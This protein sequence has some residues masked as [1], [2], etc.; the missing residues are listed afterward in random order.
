MATG[1]FGKLPASGD[2]VTRGL[3]DGVRPLL[4]RWLT[5]TLA[6]LAQRPEDWPPE[7][8]RGLIAHGGNALALLILPS[9]DTS[10][11]AFPL[12]AAALATGAGQAQVDDWADR[13]CP[14]LRLAREGELDAAGLIARI[15]ALGPDT[16]GPSL[17][18]PLLWCPGQPPQEP[19]ELLRQMVS[20]G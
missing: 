4:D 5:R 14:A 19:E 18:P 9:R 16:G 12:A 7:G 8:L 1:F 2:F 13:A 10:G 15:A 6:P 17:N 3:P 11:R 20:C